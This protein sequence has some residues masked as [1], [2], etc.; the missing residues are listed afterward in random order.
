MLF[1]LFR[2]EAPADGEKEKNLKT[3]G[4]ILEEKLPPMAL[5]Y[6]LELWKAH[7]FSFKV[8]RTRHTCLGNYTFKNGQHII[9][10]NHDLNPYAFLIT[11]VHEVAHQHTLIQNMGRRKRPLPH[12]TEW[13]TNFRQL[14]APVLTPMVFPPDLLKTLSEHMKNPPASSSGDPRLLKALRAYDGHRPAGNPTLSELSN[15]SLFYFQNKAYKK[16]E[17]RRTRT[18]VE[19]VSDKRRYTIASHVEV[20]EAV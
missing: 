10:V 14:M 8:T 16:L 13:K 15:G 12:G 7:P 19:A 3:L 1:G 2:K 17:N 6:A 4:K 18:L 5:P 20:R 11:Y 9:T